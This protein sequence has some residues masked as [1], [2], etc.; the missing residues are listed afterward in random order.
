M[1]WK[2]RRRNELNHRILIEG[3][4]QQTSYYL[5]YP[6]IK[7]EKKQLAWKWRRRN[8]LNHG[9]LIEREGQIQNTSN[10]PRYPHIKSDKQLACSRQPIFTSWYNQVTYTYSSRY[11]IIPRI[12][13]SNFYGCIKVFLDYPALYA[14][15]YEWL[16]V[17]I[18]QPFDTLSS[19]T[20]KIL[21]L[22]R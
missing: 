10:Y 22:R 6:N 2:W 14:F 19:K 21:F 18:S 9:M 1:A 11:D 12:E 5:R 3:Q 8:E 17:L 13:W 7:S 16:N 20:I 15:L 4:I